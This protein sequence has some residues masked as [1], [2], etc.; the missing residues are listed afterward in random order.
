MNF[1]QNFFAAGVEYCTFDKY[2]PAPLLRKT[3]QL[4]ERVSEASI[5][6]G[7]QGF[8][9]LHVNGTIVSKLLAPYISAVDDIIYYDRYDIAQHLQMGE[10]VIGIVL[11]NGM[12]NGFGG[13]VWD[14]HLAPFRGAP[15]VALRLDATCESGKKVEIEA[16]ESFVTSPS[17]I[18][19]DDLRS[20]EY[21][22]ARNEQPGWNKPGFDASAWTPA[23]TAVPPRGEKRLCTA[24]PIVVTG[25]RKPVSITKV[26]DGYRYDFG[27]NDAGL[28]KLIIRGKAGQEITLVHGEHLVETGEGNI[29]MTRLDGFQPPGY[30]QTDK[31]I[32]KG[33]GEEEYTPRFT[34][35]GFRYVL[36]KG[37]TEMQATPG[38]LTYKIMHSNLA[39]RG[40]FTCS[41][42]VANQLQEITRRSTL[43]NF[44]YFPTDCPHREK[45]GWT[46][47]AA[48]SAQHILLNLAAEDSFAEWLRNIYKAQNQAGTLPGIVPTGGWGFEWGNG[49]AW[50]AALTFLPYYTYRYRGDMDILRES[51]TSIF[52]Y[53]HYIERNRDKRGLVK[54]G[55]GDWCPPS[56]E[57]HEHAAPILLTDS[58]ICMS[59]CDKAAKIFR[60]LNWLHES[61]YAYAIADELRLSI[62]RYLI[63]PNT[64]LAAGEC[65]TSQAMIL[66]YGVPLDNDRPAA[67]AQL[68]RLIHENGGF[69]D[70]GIL[71]ARCIFHVLSDMGES[72]LAYNM[73]T[74]PEYPSYGNWLQRGA[75]TLWENFNKDETGIWS[76]NHH[77]F[78][79]ISSWFIQCVAGIRYNVECKG[80]TYVNPSFINALDFAE[81]FH[82]APEGEIFVRWERKSDS[83]ILLK[84]KVPTV[85]T[86]EIVLPDG[87]IF[88]E[89][90]GDKPKPLCDGEYNCIVDS[91]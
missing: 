18:Y 16:D 76:R 70:T 6:V 56:K 66:F 38:L 12:K 69:M 1:P 87:W 31:Y 58:I 51:A 30:A 35:H 11:G 2:V 4:P 14:F 39:E 80:I 20:G 27:I 7:A 33:D 19:F 83:E 37:I 81:A 57:A 75:T 36:V 49:P 10:N 62:R 67:Q 71:G 78:G 55:L 5:L 17:P 63:D 50:D 54:L 8:Y 53:V 59:I 52:R 44:Y 22:D 40:G 3:F 77:F 42:P 15:S 73:I 26:E 90:D 64:M 72:D 74:R 28:C 61:D 48:V 34:Y 89:L 24:D 84:V 60:K 88:D 85:L 46:G 43:A 86:G 82:H 29:E 23:I 21:Y 45:N 9:E 41:D 25:E 79:D 13:Y 91:I 32:C 68:L 47:D 65:Q